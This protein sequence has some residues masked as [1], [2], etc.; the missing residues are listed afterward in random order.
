LLAGASVGFTAIVLGAMALALYLLPD[1]P[2][3]RFVDAT[4]SSSPSCPL[5]PAGTARCVTVAECFD[6]V[7]VSGGVASAQKLACTEPH[8]WEAFAQAQLPAGLDSAGHAAIK[9]NTEVRQVCSVANA[10][11]LNAESPWQV[12]VLPPSR[13]Q[14]RAGDRT[15]RCLA[16]RPPTKY[17]QSRFSR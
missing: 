17:T 9:Q 8:L 3:A 15:Y 11:L 10:K 4:A 2:T 7:R 1:R 13:D 5:T 6:R 12:E 16:G 14:L